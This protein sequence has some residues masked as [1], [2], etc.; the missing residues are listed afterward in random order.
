MRTHLCGQAHMVPCYTEGMSQNCSYLGKGSGE[1]FPKG[2]GDFRQKKPTVSCC[3]SLRA[4]WVFNLAKAGPHHGMRPST[5]PLPPCHSDWTQ[6]LWCQHTWSSVELL[7]SCSWWFQM[8]SWRLRSCF[9][10]LIS[11]ILQS[12]HIL[13]QPIS[14]SQMCYMGLS[15]TIRSLGPG[16][17]ISFY[18]SSIC[19]SLVNCFLSRW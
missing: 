18:V 16:L 12:P 2:S 1:Q 8:I 7:Q 6:F 4:R 3:S 5:F 9:I 14:I 13:W 15:V 19:I 10:V 17:W 11:V